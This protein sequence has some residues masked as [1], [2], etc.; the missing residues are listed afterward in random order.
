MFHRADLMQVLYDS[1]SEVDKQHILTN[2]K[3]VDISKKKSGVEVRC[4][5]G[6][7][8]NG[9]IVIG[10]DGT[11]SKVRQS[12]RELALRYSKLELGTDK[13]YLSEYRALWC[14]FPRQPGFETG[15]TFETHATN[16]SLQFLNSHERSWIFIY[17]RLDE[18]TRD[19][20]SYS[21]S[22]VEALAT[23]WGDLPIGQQL[24]VK[25]IFPKRY[26]AG[27]ANL[28]EGIV[29]HW[30]WDRIVLVGD[31]CHKFTPNQGLGY[32][33]GIQDVVALVNELHR[34]KAVQQSGD[35]SLSRDALDS[36]FAR[37]QSNRMELL[38]KD[39]KASA[40]YTR[41]SAW[42][43]WMLWVL[44]RYILPSVPGFDDFMLTR[45]LARSIRNSPVLDFVESEEHFQGR[46]PWKHAMQPPSIKSVA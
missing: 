9:S 7:V 5:D 27:M 10:A 17:E 23:R 28:E 4:A 12:M 30:S 36:A 40:D 44:D 31:A 11:H 19:R 32:N 20:V 2:K 1:L 22:D 25:D 39:Y 16:V 18:Q 8:H 33:N 14:T 21:E 6:T 41:M 45:V 43:N 42:R 26:T 29:Q 15:D 24:R 38:K 35:D 3:V 34:S 37:Y 13:P 46:I